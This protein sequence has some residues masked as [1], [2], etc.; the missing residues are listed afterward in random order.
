MDMEL[1]PDGVAALLKSAWQAGGGGTTSAV[2]QTSGN[3]HTFTPG[4]VSPTFTME[5]SAADIVIRR[6]GGIR[7]N[8]L[9]ISATF[10]EIVT[11]SFGLEGTTRTVQGS[12][13]SPTF[14]TTPPFH[15]TGAS[16]R[17]AG[18]ANDD[19]VSFSFTTGNNIDRRGTLRKTRNWRRTVSGMFDVGLSLTLDF[20]TN[21]EYTRFL[22]EEEFEVVLHLE[23]GFVTGTS[24][25]KNTLEI[26]IPR[27]RWNTF[28]VPLTT[29]DYLE[30]TVEALILKPAAGQIFTAKLVNGEASVLGG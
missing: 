15:F 9:D 18:A 19:V 27:V 2:Y 30:A 11:A 22:N 6:F 1:T 3:L 16:V 25:P 4:S 14:T 20:S 5:A 13:A 17:S 21:A 12:A 29:E 28:G 26:T 24:G 23:A 7:V 10:G 8:T